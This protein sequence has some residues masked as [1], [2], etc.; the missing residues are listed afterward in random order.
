MPRV[1]IEPHNVTYFATPADFRA[2]LQQNHAT[3]DV[4]WVGYWRKATGTPS[5]TWEETVDAALC[6]GWID[7]LRK[8][9]DDTAYAIR[10]TPRREGSN[11]SRRNIDRY[12]ALAADGRILESGR[13]AWSKRREDRSGIY[14]FEQDARPQLSRD[15]VARLKA[16]PAAWK[17]WEA[18]PPGYKWRVAHWVMSAKRE[19]TRERRLVALIEDS[20]LGRKIKP[21][22]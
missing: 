21:F 10:F 13:T 14:S 22:R 1:P 19:E 17:D 4:L 18:R 15:Y 5:V 2:W 6:F 3:A 12:T 8:T 7:G 20:G 9:I 11:W 16:D